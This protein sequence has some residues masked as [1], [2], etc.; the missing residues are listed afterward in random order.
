MKIYLYDPK[1]FEYL[2]K[3]DARQSP[4][5]DEWLVP[6]FAT[7]LTP[8]PFGNHEVAVFQDGY[9]III[10]DYR[11]ST[12]WKPDGSSYIITTIGITPDSTDLDHDPKPSPYHENINNSWVLNR[13]LWLNIV[14][15]PKRDYLLTKCD[16]T[17]LADSPLTTDMRS[18]WSTYRQSLR[19]LP[20]N[21]SFENAVWPSPPAS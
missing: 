10:P 16:W 9:W 3:R 17:Q 2:G 8:L 4:M 15:R 12:W 20:A 19:D 5:D 1:T 6:A 7:L 14:V 11:G 13:P 21:I 18:Q